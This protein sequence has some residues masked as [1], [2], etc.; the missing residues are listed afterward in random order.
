MNKKTLLNIVYLL[1]LCTALQPAFAQNDTVKI[2]S[3]EA[4]AFLKLYPVLWQQTAAEYRALCYQAF[5]IA[6]LRLNEILRKN[7][8]KENLAIITDLDETVLDNSNIQA[9]IIKEGKEINYLGIIA[10]KAG[11]KSQHTRSCK[12]FTICGKKRAN[13]LLYK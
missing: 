10:M 6:E 2:T 1:S 9:Q 8:Q 11:L 13:Y 5:N 7:S 4:D 3:Q 12:I